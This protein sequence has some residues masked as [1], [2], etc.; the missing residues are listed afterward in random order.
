VPSGPAYQRCEDC[1]AA[2]HPHRVTCP[3]CGSRRLHEERSAG[4]G[5][6]YS[7]T[8][9]HARDGTRNVVLVDL[10]EGFRVMSEIVGMAPE[11]VAIGMGVHAS[12][13]DDGRVVFR[14]A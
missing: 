13:D 12:D 3:V 11:G 7:T 10:D 4:A 9:V 1:G 8:T 6:V 2:I 5:V 14:A